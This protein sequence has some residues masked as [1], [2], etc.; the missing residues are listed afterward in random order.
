MASQQLPLGLISEGH[1]LRSYRK[2]QHHI[3]AISNPKSADDI[4]R[5]GEKDVRFETK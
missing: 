2:R 4:M 5:D 3:R 1:Y